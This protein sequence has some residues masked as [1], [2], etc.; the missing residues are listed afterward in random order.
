MIRAPPSVIINVNNAQDIFGER[1]IGGM[2]NSPRLGALETILRPIVRFC[3]RN[4]ISVTEVDSV[5]RRVFVDLATDEIEA[6]G[7]KPTVSRIY[8]MTG[9]NRR[10]VTRIVYGD[11]HSV[12]GPD[13]LVKVLSA[14]E[15]NRDYCTSA[16]KPRLLTYDG[17]DSEFKQLV[18]SVSQNVSPASVLLELERIKSVERTESGV[19]LLQGVGFWDTVPERALGLFARDVDT[20]ARAAEENLYAAQETKN[21]YLR[22]EFD[23]ISKVDIPKIRKWLYDQGIA[24]HKRARAY[25][26]KY[27]NDLNPSVPREGGARVILSAF[28]WTSTDSAVAVGE[29]KQESG[30]GRRGQVIR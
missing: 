14:W 1:S 17:E 6:I 9:L 24:F 28:S 18:A 29:T 10:D 26:A 27:D 30:T 23:N 15:S 3:L 20:V 12:E 8:L 5:L 25:L 22:T 4:R 11:N 19:K 13:L 7:Q 21:V 16:G 2:G